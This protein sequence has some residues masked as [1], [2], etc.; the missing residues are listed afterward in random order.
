MRIVECCLLLILTVR[1]RPQT[2]LYV[3]LVSEIMS[4][5]SR[6]RVQPRMVKHVIEDLITRDFIG[7]D[8]A[9][10]TSLTYCP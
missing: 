8:E 1:L 4:R 5:V 6:F 9:N 7:R 2:M 10:P 3:Q